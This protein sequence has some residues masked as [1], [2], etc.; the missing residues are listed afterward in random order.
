MSRPRILWVGGTSALARTY[1][2]EVGSAV[3]LR[4]LEPVSFFSTGHEAPPPPPQPDGAARVR[5][6][7]SSASLKRCASGGSEGNNRGGPTGG[8]A[9]G[10]ASG[11]NCAALASHDLPVHLD[12]TDPESVVS[13]FD[14]V[15]AEHGL[16]GGFDAMVGTAKGSGR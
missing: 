9:G 11:R 2:D 8:P 13:V 1:F 15:R 12:L 3:G 5:R 4:S 7:G 14:R 6:E 16:E 10:G